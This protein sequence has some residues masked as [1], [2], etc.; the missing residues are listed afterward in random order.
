MAKKKKKSEIMFSKA[1][2]KLERH[3]LPRQTPRVA[4]QRG[5]E[6]EPSEEKREEEKLKVEESIGGTGGREVCGDAIRGEGQSG[7]SGERAGS[8]RKT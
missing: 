7:S 8:R 1:G 2:P 5:E 3:S 4:A 6:A